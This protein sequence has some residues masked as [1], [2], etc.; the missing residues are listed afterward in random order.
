M[1]V[2]HQENKPIPEGF[3]LA[4]LDSLE[5]TNHATFGAN[6]KWSFVIKE[7]PNDPSAVGTTVTG[8]SSMKVS[9]KS[10]MFSWLQAFGVILGGNDEFELDDLIG[11]MVK[12]QITNNV[13]PSMVDG[14][15]RTTTYSNVTALAAYIPDQT[16]AVPP[17]VATAP[18]A[19]PATAA[20]A[21]AAPA[22]AQ[23]ASP[24]PAPATA[25]AVQ[26]TAAVV[27]PQALNADED[28]GF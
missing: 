19:A 14:Q 17:P 7:S 13:K 16:Q 24:S 6:I 10:K 25:T 28:F 15:E 2:R 1:K 18:A 5:E 22:A 8:M 3:Y 20:P 21:V 4:Q 12:V 23:V 27:D 11:R 26:G 9:P